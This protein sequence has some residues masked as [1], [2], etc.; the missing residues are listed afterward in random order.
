MSLPERTVPVEG[1]CA[2]SFKVPV[3]E[4]RSAAVGRSGRGHSGRPRPRP[5]VPPAK[6]SDSPS[7]AKHS[8]WDQSPRHLLS[9][10]P[11]WRWRSWCSWLRRLRCFVS[12]R[13]RRHLWAAA[14]TG[15]H[16]PPS[17]T[18]D[19]GSPS[20]RSLPGLALEVWA[21]SVWAPSVWVRLVW[22]SRQA[23]PWWS[24]R[25]AEESRGENA[26]LKQENGR[27]PFGVKRLF[28]LYIHLGNLRSKVFY[29][30]LTSVMANAVS[31]CLLLAAAREVS[32]GAEIAA[33]LSQQDLRTAFKK[34]NVSN[35]LQ[36]DF[37]KSLF[38]PCGPL[39]L[40]GLWQSTSS[41]VLMLIWLVCSS[42]FCCCCCSC[43]LTNAVYGIFTRW[44]WV[45]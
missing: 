5:S 28:H 24:E 26:E 38:R 11:R 15:S 6:A 32:V 17:C 41:L 40:N 20:S 34:E 1:C 10:R 42:V 4:Q 25:R 37:D 16:R 12:R 3:E 13:R 18:N 23:D 2:L 8:L 43:F 33:G 31:C 22:C 9:R 30:E 21:P 44:M 19:T 39:E 14:G 35:L 29:D 45:L 7:R 27:N 36:T